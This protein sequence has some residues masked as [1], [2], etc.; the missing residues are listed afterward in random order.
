MLYKI[1]HGSLAML[2]FVTVL[3]KLKQKEKKV[4]NYTSGSSW[5]S[6]AVVIGA[7]LLLVRSVKEYKTIHLTNTISTFTF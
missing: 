7:T 3:F 6:A 1:K 4:E 2:Y 5:Q